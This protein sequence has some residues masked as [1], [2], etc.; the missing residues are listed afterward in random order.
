MVL[1]IL[2]LVGGS[3]SAWDRHSWGGSRWGGG[4]H[5]GFGFGVFVGPPTVYYGVSTYSYP[6]PYRVW[7][8]GYW[9]WRWSGYR[10]ERVW[11]PGHWQWR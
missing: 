7:V 5:G 10:W 6:P 9:D 8:P 4:Y 3:A 1:L 11:I 2:L